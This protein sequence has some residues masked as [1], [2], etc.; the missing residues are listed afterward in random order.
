MVFDL[1]HFY[2]GKQEEEIVVRDFNLL[3]FEPDCVQCYLNLYPVSKKAA[4]VL[5]RSH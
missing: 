5:E 1:T 3:R 2:L 4:K